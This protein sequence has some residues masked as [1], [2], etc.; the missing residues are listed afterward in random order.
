LKRSNTGIENLDLEQL[1]L[2][3]LC[4]P[5]EEI[6]KSDSQNIKKG[7]N[8]DVFSVS[9]KLWTAKELAEYLGIGIN[10]SYTLMRSKGFPTT[11]LGKKKYVT[12]EA[13]D[14]WLDA[15]KGKTFVMEER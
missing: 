1:S 10:K 6:A 14:E 4:W 13:V 15:Y 2:F 12:R 3:D 11:H 5:S 7:Q 8:P 9:R